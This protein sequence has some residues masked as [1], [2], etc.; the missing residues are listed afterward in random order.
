[1]RES[2]LNK[3][4][5]LVTGAARIYLQALPMVKALARNSGPAE[6][7]PKMFLRE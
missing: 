4:L 6:G 7:V 5:A 2:L 3:A 1:M